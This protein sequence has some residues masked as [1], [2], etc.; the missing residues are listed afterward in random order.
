MIPV[1]LLCCNIRVLNTCYHSF[2]SGH[3]V[4]SLEKDKDGRPLLQLSPPSISVCSFGQLSRIVQLANDKGLKEVR[5]GLEGKSM[6]PQKKT[7][8][9]QDKT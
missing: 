3:E 2:R 4:E 5:A 9:K 7:K 6:E 8:K 1:L